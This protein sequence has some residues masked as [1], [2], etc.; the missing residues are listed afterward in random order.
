MCR[1]PRRWSSPLPA[2]TADGSCA[3]DPSHRRWSLGTEV[4]GPARDQR[5]SFEHPPR[6]TCRRPCPEYGRCHCGCGEAPKNA[7]STDR[8]RDQWK[9]QPFVFAQ[10]HHVRLFHPRTGAFCVVGVDAEQ[11]RPL[12]FWLRSRHG[13][14]SIVARLLG[15]PE[16]TVRGYAYKQ[17]LRRIPPGNAKIIVRAVLAH[18]EGLH[19]RNSW[20]WET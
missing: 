6:G 13:T 9:G 14:M 4:R 18:R 10:G 11:V 2:G 5:W 3:E 17:S 12:I 8:P 20:E 7:R 15:L 1:D 19:R 16:S